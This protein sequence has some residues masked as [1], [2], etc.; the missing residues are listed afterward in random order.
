MIVLQALIL[1]IGGGLLLALAQLGVYGLL[2]RTGRRKPEDVPFF[3]LLLF[4]G[5]ALMFLLCAAGA[6]AAHLLAGPVKG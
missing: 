3:G 4:R 2:T 5:V 6:V 1:L